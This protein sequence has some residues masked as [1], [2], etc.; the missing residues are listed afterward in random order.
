MSATEQHDSVMG[1]DPLAWIAQDADEVDDAV[2]PVAEAAAAEPEPT[3][4]AAE[5]EAVQAEQPAAV[6]TAIALAEQAASGEVLVLD[7]DMGIANINEWHVTFREALLKHAKITVQAEGLLH[8]D[9]AALQ[10]LYA[11]QR[12]A[13]TSEV[14]VVWQG[15]SDS[16]RKTADIIAL[17]DAMD[18]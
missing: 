18:W 13:K 5:Q 6:E 2:A 11:F 8:V 1:H 10:L 3:P 4:Q 16:V 17:S 7:G 12:E 9:T 15:V 14:E